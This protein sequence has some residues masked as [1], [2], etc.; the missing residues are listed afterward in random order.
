MEKYL[1]GLNPSCDKCRQDNTATRKQKKASDLNKEYSTWANLYSMRAL[2]AVLS[3]FA[4]V[5]VKIQLA[6]WS[7]FPFFGGVCT[8]VQL[9][10]KK[11]CA[12][13]ILRNVLGQAIGDLHFH[14]GMSQQVVV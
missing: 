5:Q 11:T 1:A 6:T 2:T 3:E 7:K 9:S 4:N 12:H 8:A 10:T 13:S 14:S